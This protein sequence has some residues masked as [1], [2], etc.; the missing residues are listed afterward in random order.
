MLPA[1]TWQAFKQATGIGIINSIGSTEMLHSF[2]SSAG[3]E[4]PPGSLGK[5]IRGYEACLLDGDGKCVPVGE[6]GRLAVR[7]PT[8]CRYLDDERQALQVQNGW[9]LT[10]DLCVLD[11]EGTT[12]TA[13][14]GTT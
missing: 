10:G 3:S 5:P 9:T 1:A 14:A 2:M 6:T 12:G 8:G 7:G 4:T 13:P 11:A